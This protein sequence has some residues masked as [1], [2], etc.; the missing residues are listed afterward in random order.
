MHFSLCIVLEGKR[1]K[2]RNRER[3][4]WNKKDRK[5]KNFFEKEEKPEENRSLIFTVTV[6]VTNIMKR[7][8]VFLD[9]DFFYF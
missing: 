7:G 9:M 3:N 1:V 5:N 4:V 2:D 6:L 8:K